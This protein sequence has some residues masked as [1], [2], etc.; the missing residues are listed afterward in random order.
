MLT[1]ST[2]TKSYRFL[3]VHG[4]EGSPE[5]NW[6]PWIKDAL[7]KDGYIVNVPCFPTPENQSFDSWHQVALPYLKDGASETTILIGHSTGAVFVLRLAE[8]TPVPFHAV[9]SVCPFNANLGFEKY[10]I[11]NATFTVQHHFDWKK[12]KEGSKDFSLYAGDNDPYVP[13]SRSQEIADSLN[14]PLHI[15]KN[16]GHLNGESGF[17]K[18]DQLL[19]DIQKTI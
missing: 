16:G 2:E 1:A 19:N 6:F 11:L 17:T 3:I 18:F 7:E 4:T 5:I 12:I 13:L 14:A 15:V 10:D 8:L 9:F